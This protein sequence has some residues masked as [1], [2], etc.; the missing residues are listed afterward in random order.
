MEPGTADTA[1]GMRTVSSDE[2]IQLLRHLAADERTGTLAARGP[3]GQERHIFFKDGLI[4]AVH[5]PASADDPFEK[6]I[7]A[8]RTFS[9][10]E[11]AAAREEARAGGKSL[12]Q[13]LLERGASRGLSPDRIMDRCTF[14][15]TAKIAS[16]TTIDC[17]F[18]DGCWP[19]GLSEHSACR[20]GGGIDAEEILEML[21]R[22][23]SSPGQPQVT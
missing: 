8:D 3:S 2:F 23:T 15:E 12:A 6:A 4:K 22:R 19:A 18:D 9:G 20:T 7:V 10:S 11:I 5:N 14:A 16:W 17:R 1:N 13:V 21:I